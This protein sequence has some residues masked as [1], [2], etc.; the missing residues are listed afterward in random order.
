MSVWVVEGKKIDIRGCLRVSGREWVG[1]FL[2]SWDSLFSFVE[3]VYS[4]FV[5]VIDDNEGSVEIHTKKVHRLEVQRHGFSA[6]RS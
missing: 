2:S 3:F 5:F 1:L 4:R 6:E